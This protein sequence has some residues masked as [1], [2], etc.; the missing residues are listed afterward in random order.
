[1]QCVWMDDFIKPSHKLHS[2]L[3]RMFT[4]IV[5]PLIIAFL[6]LKSVLTQ[7]FKAC[8][9]RTVDNLSFLL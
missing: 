8:G 2:Q 4:S 3:D 9:E 5:N 7:A 6:S 1:M